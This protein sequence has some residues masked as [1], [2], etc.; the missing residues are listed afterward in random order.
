MRC[1]RLCQAARRV[2]DAVELSWRRCP[3]PGHRVLQTGLA[4]RWRG[5]ARAFR[6]AP[7][8]LESVPTTG[9]PVPSRENADMSAVRRGEPA[10]AP[11]ATVHR[12]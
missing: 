5:G 12:G 11:I 1:P 3:A 7:F 9:L 2:Y 6:K 10:R 4:E 8:L